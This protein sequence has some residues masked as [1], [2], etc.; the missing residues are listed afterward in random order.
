MKR[1][2][3]VCIHNSARSQIAEAFFRKHAPESFEAHSAGIEPGILN[4]LAVSTM[5]EAGI[6]I[7][8][9]QTKSVFELYRS[10]RQFDYVITVCDPASAAGCPVFEGECTRLTWSFPD[11]S[12][13]QGSEESKLDQTRKV[14]DMIETKVVEFIRHLTLSDEK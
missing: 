14:R 5:H 2:L 13:F 3:F 6:D 9:A 11:P 4:P 10:G 8:G 7:S 12:S 1:V